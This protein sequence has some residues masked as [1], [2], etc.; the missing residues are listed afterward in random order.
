MWKVLIVKLF[1]LTISINV[2]SQD[3]NELFIGDTL[4]KF[5]IKKVINWKESKIHSSEL[6]GR[7]KILIFWHTKCS[8]CIIALFKLDSLNIDY[9]Q[10]LQVI[11]IAQNDTKETI[12]NLLNRI[13]KRG[14]I[15]LPISIGDSTTF[16]L[17]P[18]NIVSHIV[19]INEQNIIMGITGSGYLTK[20]KIQQFLDGESLN[21]W[22]VKRDIVKYDKSKPFFEFA[23][24]QLIAPKFIFS[25]GL[26][27]HIKGINPPSGR[28]VDSINN[29]QTYTYF[30]VSLFDLI[31]RSVANWKESD[32][33]FNVKDRGR[34]VF[35]KQSVYSEWAQE[36]TFCYSISLPLDLSDNET[37]K[38]IRDDLIKWLAILRVRVLRVGNRYII[39]EI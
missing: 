4:P 1:F 18:H 15:S 13:S 33:E 32:F 10:K 29:S 20:D 25:S 7:K 19:W 23:Q 3:F 8:S 17:F 28:K 9:S 26:T 22:F 35:F 14:K 39:S 31:R 21:T 38:I 27:A 5:T 37:S 34:Y 6:I 12:E 36:N 11:S 30:N 16:K 2:N 24:R